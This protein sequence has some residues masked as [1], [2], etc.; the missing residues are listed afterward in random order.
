MKDW[1]PRV[2]GADDAY[3]DIMN[4]LHDGNVILMHQGSEDN[5]VALD[6]IIKGIKDAGYEFAL[7]NGL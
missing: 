1:V 2:H 3:K 7:V 5:I 6:K 4:N